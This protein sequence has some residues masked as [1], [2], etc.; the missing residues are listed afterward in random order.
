MKIIMWKPAVGRPRF[1]T[2]AYLAHQPLEL[3]R[4]A[5]RCESCMELLFRG[6]MPWL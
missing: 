3:R 1:A 5:L 2:S 4:Y 6:P